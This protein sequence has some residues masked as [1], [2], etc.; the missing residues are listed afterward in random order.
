MQVVQERSQSKCRKDSPY[1]HVHLLTIVYLSVT[2]MSMQ[3]SEWYATI[4]DKTVEKRFSGPTN[5][6]ILFTHQQFRPP[7]FNPLSVLFCC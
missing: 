2:L 4:L 3:L 1:I 6:A 5:F 7:L